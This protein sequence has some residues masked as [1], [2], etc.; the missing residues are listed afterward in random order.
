[1]LW[2]SKTR[3]V[4]S[5]I[6]EVIDVTAQPT[7]LPVVTIEIDPSLAVQILFPSKSSF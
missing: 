4:A 2:P 6:P 7:P 1:M 5:V 3:P